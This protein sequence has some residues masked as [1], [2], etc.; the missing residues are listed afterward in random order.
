MYRQSERNLL[1]SNISCRCPHNMVNFGLLMAGICLPVWSTTP[2]NYN[3]FR[4][5]ASLPQRRRSPEAN[6][7]LHDLWSSPGLVHYIYISGGFCPLTEFCH[8]QNSLC[9][10]V[11]LSLMLAALVHGTPAAGLS[12]TLRCTTRKGITE[13]SHT[14]QPI[15]GRAAITLGIGPHSSF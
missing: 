14:A 2:A 4:I 15:F 1:N 9:V 8:V 5:L 3:R 10:Q 13:L 11:L 12:Q 7:A 6:Q